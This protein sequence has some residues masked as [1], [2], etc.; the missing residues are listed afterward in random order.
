MPKYSTT[1]SPNNNRHNTLSAK[2]QLMSAP[3]SEA[4]GASNAGHQIPCASGG[5]NIYVR[6]SRTSERTKRG[7]G[8]SPRL[9]L[10]GAVVT[11]AGFRLYAHPPNFQFRIRVAI[12]ES[13]VF[14]LD[15][16]VRRRAVVR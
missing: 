11:L 1:I 16:S 5:R 8:K 9:L 12:C 15:G 4:A 3:G 2:S 7:R 13:R 10:P 6:M 14:R